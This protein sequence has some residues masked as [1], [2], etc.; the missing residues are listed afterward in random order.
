MSSL[1][2]KPFYRRKLPHLQR[3]FKPHFITFCTHRRWILPNRARS[4]VLKC[5]L[6]DNGSTALI[7][8]VVVMPDHVHVVFTPLL[9]ETKR[10][11]YSL[12]T[13]M[14]RIKG[15][16]AHLINR[17]LGSKGRVWQAESF[18]RVLRSSESLDAKIAYI[19][20]NPVRGGLVAKWQDY[21]WLWY[22]SLPNP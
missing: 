18:D 8:A 16:S 4:I 19:L 6:H 22:A 21:P 2:L 7:H 12:A 10:E 15:A 13:I 9:N 11:V 20:E 1:E 3:D 5:C 14:D 17:M